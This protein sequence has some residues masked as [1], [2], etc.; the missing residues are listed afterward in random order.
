MM[1]PSVD[2]LVEERI[3]TAVAAALRQDRTD[4]RERRRLRQAAHVGQTT[5]AP[6]RAQARSRSPHQTRAEVEANLFPEDWLSP[7]EGVTPSPSDGIPPSPFTSTS[8]I[9]TRSKYGGVATP[10]PTSRPSA[11][12]AVIS[13]PVEEVQPP[14]RTG[15]AAKEAQP[16]EQQRRLI[17][18]KEDRALRAIRLGGATYPDAPARPPAP[19]SRP[20]PRPSVEEQRNIRRA[21]R[22]AAS[23]AAW[24][25]EQDIIAEEIVSG[26]AGSSG[27][28]A[29]PP[30]P[31]P[32]RTRKFPRGHKFH[33]G[34][35]LLSLPLERRWAVEEPR[36]EGECPP[37]W[38]IC[39]KFNR[40]DCSGISMACL[41]ARIHA[42][43][44]CGGDHPAP[45]CL[46]GE[47]DLPPPDPPVGPPLRPTRGA[48][49]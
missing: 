7:S 44:E 1:W 15:G 13:E 17:R 49:N 28:P 31:P 18:L 42:C 27:A 11:A 35:R 33:A 46:V 5:R 45:Y 23:D 6:A 48:G 40:G 21:S 32:T 30:P 14:P 2:A 26:G 29:A 43:S 22:A 3:A 8:T 4:R 25:D 9:S 19:S 47:D 38:E 39:R 37:T 34:P 24:R 36:Y 41:H 20:D 16:E 10:P 12:Q